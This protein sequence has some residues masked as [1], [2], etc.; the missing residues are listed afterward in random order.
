[1]DQLKELDTLLRQGP[2]AHG[3]STN[4]WTSRRIA[5]LIRRHFTVSYHPDHALRIVKRRLG[6]SCQKPTRRALER[7]EDAIKLWKQKEFPRI[8]KRKI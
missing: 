8:K 4:I 7:D 5:I 3:W 2:L 6:W 1:M